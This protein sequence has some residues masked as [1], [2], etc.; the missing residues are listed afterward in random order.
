MNDKITSWFWRN[1][2]RN[3]LKVVQ[4]FPY[5]AALAG[6]DWE[7]KENEGYPTRRKYLYTAYKDEHGFDNFEK[8]NLEY[9]NSKTDK[10]SRA[11]NDKT[12]Y[13]FFGLGFVEGKNSENPGNIII[14]DVGRKIID[15][16]FDEEIYLKQ[17]LKVRFSKNEKD[18]VYPMELILKTIDEF[19]Y[20]NR[21]ELGFLYECMNID[22]IDIVFK[23]IRLFR[24]QFKSLENK[25]SKSQ[26]S[27]LFVSIH[28]EVC[29]REPINKPESYFS[30]S[31]AVFRSLIF[32]N[33]IFK[34]SGRGDL[35]RISIAPYG[36]RKFEQL[37]KRYSFNHNLIFETQNEYMDW[38]GNTNSTLLPWEDT[39][40]RKDLIFEKIKF[41][42]EEVNKNKDVLSDL[43][44]NVDEY[45]AIL[46]SLTIVDEIKKLERDI[47]IDITTLNETIFIKHSS[48]TMSERNNILDRYQ[49]ILND[50]DLAAMWFEVNTWKSLI[51]IDGEKMVKRNFN[52]QEN[53][54]PKS[55]APGVGNT[56]DMELYFDNYILIPEVS[57]MSGTIQWEHEG[58]SV[59]DHVKKFIDKNN[60]KNVLGLFI[61][62]KIDNRTL[63]QFFVLSKNSWAGIPIPVIPL[64]I[65]QYIRLL[66]V[67]YK[68]N[69]DIKQFIEFLFDIYKGTLKLERY[70]IWEEMIE[71][72]I[73]S[74]EKNYD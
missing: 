56:P 24:E 26:I 41:L 27:E 21:I 42:E 61:S 65:N 3:I 60:N 16:L 48:K 73:C 28:K 19:E 74:L 51:S 34:E 53:L 14:T 70:D 32:L 45:K 10:E 55:F 43:D 9:F 6:E 49:D 63:W 8:F 58:S 54:T 13:E 35:T 57:L 18:F 12:T 59:I 5:F 67:V 30:Y 68:N 64:T 2:P 7:N 20:L 71:N 46:T 4:W 22:Q 69:I 52:I 47:I 31:D 72:M 1:K 50:G 33:S 11:R 44:I 25:F 37:L 62:K 15:E 29:G 38:F 39:I 17:L 66:N 36:K 23:E 40:L